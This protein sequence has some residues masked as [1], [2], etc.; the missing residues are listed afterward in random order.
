MRMVGVGDMCLRYA[1]KIRTRTHIPR[2]LNQWAAQSPCAYSL[3]LFLLAV[4]YRMCSTSIEVSTWFSSNIVLAGVEKAPFAIY[5][6]VSVSPCLRKDQGSPSRVWH[7][8]LS[9]N[10]LL[11]YRLSKN[12]YA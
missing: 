11:L 10:K 7:E 8:E 5:I 9:R 2:R 3:L 1:M 12:L 6:L 4:W